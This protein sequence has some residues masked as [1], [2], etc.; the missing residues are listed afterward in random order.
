M[1]GL[2]CST[3]HWSTEHVEL[4]TASRHAQ[5]PEKFWIPI[6]I[7]AADGDARPNCGDAPFR[8]P[9]PAYPS[10]NI[11]TATPSL[12]PLWAEGTAGTLQ[13]G[14]LRTLLLSFLLLHR[15]G[16]AFLKSSSCKFLSVHNRSPRTQ[17]TTSLDELAE[18]NNY[19]NSVETS[20]THV[21]ASHQN[22]VAQV[23]NSTLFLPAAFL[24]LMIPA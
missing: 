2:T 19:S 8:Q 23:Q 14:S 6:Q 1:S 4:N 3:E 21:F 15:S 18:P 12:M 16:N 13:R 10:A 20:S 5:T 17:R 24:G 7:Y 9:C 11:A 22:R